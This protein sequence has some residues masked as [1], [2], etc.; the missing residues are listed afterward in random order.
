[1]PERFNKIWIGLVPGLLLPIV[2]FFGY[3]LVV[4]REDHSLAFFVKGL[5]IMD[6]YTSVLAILVLPNL[7]LF[8]V[9]IW[10][11]KLYSA[12]GV[13]MATI[14]YAFIVFGLKFLT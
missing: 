3:Y 7:L 8:F 4:F 11:N 10:T 12:R 6:L 1:M 13:L 5:I 14:I 9:F 2:T